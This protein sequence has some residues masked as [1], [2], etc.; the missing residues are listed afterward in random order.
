MEPMLGLDAKFLYSETPTAHMHTLKVAVFDMSGVPGGYH[1]DRI[2][3]L[4]ERRLDRIPVFRRRIVPVPLALG[5]PVWI[6]DP[7][8]DISRQVRRRPVAPPGGSRQLAD[9]VAEIAGSPLARDRPLWELTVVEGLADERLAVVAKVHHA[10]ADGSASVALLLRALDPGPRPPTDV[11]HPEPVPTAG[12]LLRA[13]A[14]GH[15]ERAGGVPRLLARSAGGLRDAASRRRRA[16]MRP[17]LPFS[18]ARTPFNV[19]LTPERTFAMTTVPL[20]DLKAVRRAFGATLNDVFLAM[21]SGAIRAYLL[22]LG[23]LPERPLVASVPVA[24]SSDA[25]AVGGNHVDNLYVSIA[26]ECPDPAERIR[27]IR[28]VSVGAKAVR[29]ALGNDLLEERAEIVPPQLYRLAIRAWTRS[30]LAD[31]LRPPVNVI[32]SNVPGPAQR[33]CFGGAELEALYSVGPILEGI[34]CNITAWSYAGTLQVSVLGCPRS[35]PDPW[36][37]ADRLPESLRE[38]TEA[39]TRSRRGASIR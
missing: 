19:S 20:E 24:T 26:T 16:P 9:L 35:L 21:C 25:P 3:G 39:C 10:V 2:V 14:R 38:L 34:G 12:T 31:R 7:D 5:H 6:E 36:L 17:P 11:A 33:L 27:R 37:L 13:A 29:A 8:F 15:R 32:L 1:F 23:A 28:D 30:R 22:S 4:L 18:T